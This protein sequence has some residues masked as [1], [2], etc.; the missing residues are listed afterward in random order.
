MLEQRAGG[1]GG[2]WSDDAM[3]TSISSRNT[4][5]EVEGESPFG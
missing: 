3:K 5:L 1:I 2:I 4:P